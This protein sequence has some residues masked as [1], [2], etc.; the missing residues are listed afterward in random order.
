[1]YIHLSYTKRALH[2]GILLKLIYIRPKCLQFLSIEK[3][4]SYFCYITFHR[5]F[6]QLSQKKADATCS[7]NLILCTTN[8]Y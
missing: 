1:M 8:F 6:K 3:T 7:L 2:L 4:V 5:V